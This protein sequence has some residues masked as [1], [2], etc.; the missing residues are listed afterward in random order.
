MPGKPS[1]STFREQAA[2]PANDPGAHQRPFPPSAGYLAEIDGKPYP[3][4]PTKPL[5]RIGGTMDAPIASSSAK[6]VCIVLAKYA[7]KMGRAWPSV[8]AISQKASLSERTVQRAIVDLKR[9][10][11]LTAER[12]VRLATNYRLKLPTER[13][14]RECWTAI[15]R[16]LEPCPS[17][18]AYRVRELPL[19]PVGGDLQG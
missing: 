11:W 5:D 19:L 15:P 2:E 7:D 6:V 3:S 1:V 14:C 16:R 13:H 9:A 4:F 18:G 17:C 10:G 12:R 8:S